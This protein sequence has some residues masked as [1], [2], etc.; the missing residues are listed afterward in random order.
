MIKMISHQTQVILKYEEKNTCSA[1]LLGW[2]IQFPFHKIWLRLHTHIFIK[3][4][5]YI[6]NALTVGYIKDDVLSMTYF[7]CD[8]SPEIRVVCSGL[9]HGCNNS[10]LLTHQNIQDVLLPNKVVNIHCLMNQLKQIYYCSSL[11]GENRMS[12]EWKMKT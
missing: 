10:F 3:T 1:A 4:H 8:S 5:K 9:K 2:S 12:I 11:T 7:W 6:H